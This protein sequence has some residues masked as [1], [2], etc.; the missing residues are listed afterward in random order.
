[1]APFFLLASMVEEVNLL[2]CQEE[3]RPGHAGNFSTLKTLL[4][5]ASGPS[6]PTLASPLRQHPKSGI[7]LIPS[8]TLPWSPP[9]G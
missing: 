1:M 3:S 4:S 6:W 9:D 8:A 5:G 7:S 2:F